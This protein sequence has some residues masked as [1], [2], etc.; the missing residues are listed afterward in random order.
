[1]HKIQAMAQFIK[2]AIK[3]DLLQTGLRRPITQ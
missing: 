2:S 1:M 3:L